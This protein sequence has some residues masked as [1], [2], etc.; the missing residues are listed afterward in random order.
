MTL[1]IDFKRRYALFVIA[2]ALLFFLVIHFSNPPL[3]FLVDASGRIHYPQDR[4][5]LI[6]KEEA[7]M[8]TEYY[9][10]INVTFNSN[11]TEIYAKIWLPKGKEKHAALLFLPGAGGTKDAG[12]DYA[13]I[14]RERNIAIF[15]LD[16]RGFGQ[17]KSSAMTFQ[18][19]FDAFSSGREYPSVLMAYD[20]LRAFDYLR[21]RGDIDSSNIIVL[22]ESLGGRNAI[23]AGA[24]DPR[25]K[26]V[27]G[28]STGGWGVTDAADQ[29]VTRF[30]R[31][32]DPDNYISQISPRKTVIFHSEADSTQPFEIGLRTYNFA[33]EPKAF[34]REKCATHGLCGEMAPK[35]QDEVLAL[36]GQ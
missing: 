11:G 9:R 31:S 13:E 32:F 5:E 29:N 2:A 8:E 34:Y 15:A 12:K 10:T 23:I 26:A 30:L 24:I 7:G 4:G 6:F 17:T 28:I 18:Q 35:I 19:E 1:N 20:A 21:Q 33:K 14:F 3:K 22:G 16:Q 25:F 36:V 27:I